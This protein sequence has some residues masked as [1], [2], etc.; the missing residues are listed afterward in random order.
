MLVVAPAS[1][2][3][4]ASSA[5]DPRAEIESLIKAIED[6]GQRAELLK[7]LRQARGA[8]A[9]AD[10]EEGIG[11]RVVGG[12]AHSLAETAEAFVS[13][14]RVLATA[15]E[16]IEHTVKIFADPVRRQ[17]LLLVIGQF[18]F[19][20]AVAWIVDRWAV[21]P[22]HRLLRRDGAEAGPR[23][24]LWRLPPLLVGLLLDLIAPAILVGV[25][26]LLV[27][28]I[29][30][31]GSP[32]LAAIAL[33]TAA[34]AT[35]VVMAVVRFL[36]APERGDLRLL[37]V[38]GES[39]SYLVVWIRRFSIV[40]IFGYC[41]IEALTLLGL[42]R[43]ARLAMLRVL[44]FIL[45]VMAVIFIL[46]NRTS[47]RTWL[48]RG[49]PSGASLLG[50]QFR[51]RFGEIWH[52]VAILYVLACFFVWAADATGG[53]THLVRATFLTGIVLSLSAFV[54][55]LIDFGA[56]RAFRIG[57]EMRLRHPGLEA[58]A[59]LYL[60]LLQQLLRVLLSVVTLLVVLQAWGLDAFA[61]LVAGPGLRFTSGLLTLSVVLIAALVIWELANAWIER[62]LNQKDADGLRVERGARAKTLLPLLRNALMVALIVVCALIALSEIGVNIAPLLAGAGVV[63]L[64]IG[65]GSQKLVQDVITGFFLLVE[66]A[67]AIGDVV[68]VG[69]HAGV[70][71]GL[72]IRSMR[73]RDFAGTV[74]TIPFSSVDRVSNLTKDFSYAVFDVMVSY[75]S[76]VDR[77]I[78]TL[79]EVGADLQTDPAFRPLI[80][81]P[82][83]I[84][85]LDQFGES[86][87]VV[88]AR[89]MTRPIQQWNVSR[90]FNRRMKRRFD[91]LGIEMPFRNVTVH[92]TRNQ[93][94]SAAAAGAAG[95]AAQLSK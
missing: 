80:L 6:D 8:T 75:T 4:A 59:N 92:I 17:S 57:E 85:G 30:L 19:V 83:E 70:V 37:P 32:R 73:L 43:S 89:F 22:V 9:T 41:L 18:L 39:A 10:P 14:G 47:V 34:A 69:S 90:E 40:A 13:L 62:Y 2:Q 64:A 84:A 94:E 25:A 31:K 3:Q 12:L 58:R 61:W 91:E 11:Q 16:L 7:A 26:A 74:H 72:T 48:E 44:G 33:V 45:A 35:G 71:E 15:P 87:I 68:S 55:R 27:P 42:D 81:A 95:A 50:R 51:A 88:K 76:D 67:I 54:M 86:G 82:L 49:P 65:F 1:A 29:G 93:D 36:L 20:F 79:K 56:K 28:M 38:T 63:G 5:H 53:L 23:P 21:R 77:V 24:W 66:D 52:V 78:A 60:P 46:Q